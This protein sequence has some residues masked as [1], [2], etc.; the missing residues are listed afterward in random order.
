MG[1]LF[2]SGGGDGEQTKVVDTIFT[3]EIDKDKPLL[4]IPI[5]REPNETEY[6]SCFDWIHSVFNP[7]GINEITMWTDLN[8]KT[9]ADVRQFSAIYI[10]GGNTTSLYK[11]LIDTGFDKVLVNYFNSGGVIYGGSAGAIIMGSNIMTCAYSDPN[12]VGLTYFEGLNL[13]KDY[14]IWCHYEEKEDSLIQDFIEKYNKPVISLPEG[15]AIFV[16]RD[17][18]QVIGTENAVVFEDGRKKIM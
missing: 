7:L 2:I 11:E 9:V 8:N 17:G 6:G 5:A 16:N 12:H 10:G 14:S 18:L 1:K 3:G 15:T 13:V 4:Y